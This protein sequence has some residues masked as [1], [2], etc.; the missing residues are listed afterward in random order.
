VDKEG[1]KTSEKKQSTLVILLS[2][3]MPAVALV[4]DSLVGQGLLNG[5]WAMVA[6]LLSAG[7][8][9]AGY[10]HSRGRVKAAEAVAR[11]AKKN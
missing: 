9:S 10:S 8:A 4:L 5:T 6:G 2:V 7:I 1:S 3:T 11:V